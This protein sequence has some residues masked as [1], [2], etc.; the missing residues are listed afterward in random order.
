MLT[1]TDLKKINSNVDKIVDQKITKRGVL[2]RKDFASIEKLV[3]QAIID[4]VPKELKK[5]LAYL[6]SKKEFYD[7]M[8]EVVGELRKSRE[9]FELI[10]RRVSDH[11]DRLGKLENIHPNYQHA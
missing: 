8:D 3:E 6:P 11:E 2:T 10:P 7:K 9:V 1:Q 4:T 5:H